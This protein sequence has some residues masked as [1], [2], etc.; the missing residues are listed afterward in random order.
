MA[1]LIVF[2]VQFVRSVGISKFF[3]LLIL[4]FP[5]V[6]L[7]LT[8]KVEDY[9]SLTT[10]IIVKTTG[11]VLAFDVTVIVLLMIPTLFVS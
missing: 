9:F 10:P 11:L 4:R 1:Y 8:F 7:E 5:I 3:I 2:L 6:F